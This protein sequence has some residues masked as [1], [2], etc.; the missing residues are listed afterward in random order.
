[1]TYTI[2][3][4]RTKYKPNSTLS[5]VFLDIPPLIGRFCYVL[6]DTV[7]GEGI[8]IDGETAIPE[9]KGKPYKVGV[10]QSPRFGEVLVL[11]DRIELRNGMEVYIIDRDIY[12]EYV[13]IHGGNTVEHT[14]GCLIAAHKAIENEDE[15]RVFDKASDELLH[16][17]KS[18]I[19]E[20]ESKGDSV[21]WEIINKPQK[22]WLCQ[23]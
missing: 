7:R 19:K 12:F 9:T 16:T 20:A 11:Y 10:R 23:F 22:G 4:H 21:L 17:L 8:K 1:M 3:Q 18:Y 14:D 15:Y 2:T 13:L 5:E 6:E